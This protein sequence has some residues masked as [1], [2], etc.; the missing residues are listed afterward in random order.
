MRA[1]PLVGAVSGG[2]AVALALA[3]VYAGLAVMAVVLL[4]AQRHAREAAFLR[5]LGVTGRQVLGL[6]VIEQG[7]PLVIA[8]VLGIGLGVGLA[9]LLQPGIDLAAFSSPDATVALAVDPISIARRGGHDR[10]G[11]RPGDRPQ[12]VARPAARHRPDAADRRGL[13]GPVTMERR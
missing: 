5:T 13:T 3:A 7:V 10:A 11:R 12:L 8:L 6:T 9:S 2:F 4:H 1:T